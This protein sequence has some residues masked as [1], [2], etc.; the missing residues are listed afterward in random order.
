MLL[1]RIGFQI[2]INLNILY[3]FIR[4][5]KKSNPVNSSPQPTRVYQSHRAHQRERILEVAESLFVRDGIDRVSLSD[6]ARAARITRATLYEYFPNKQEVAWAIFQQ[7]SEGMPSDW[8]FKPDGSGLERVEHFM[9]AMASFLETHPQRLRFIVEFNTL[10]AREGDPDRVRQA[11]AERGDLLV[12]CIRQGIEDGSIRPDFDP[13]LL[14]AAIFNL[15]N[16][17]NSRFALL[18]DLIGV[19]YG[20]PVMDM[21]REICRAFLRGIQSTSFP[22]ETCK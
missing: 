6:I 3:K 2:K 17:M 21:Y 8:L 14:S 22:Q 12:Q 15:L 11:W 20:Q 9:L 4:F 7:M 16:G 5:V 10:Y 18:G 19:E 1:T 13:Q